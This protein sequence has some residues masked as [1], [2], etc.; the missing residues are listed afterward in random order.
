MSFVG[1]YNDLD[2]GGVIT[3]SVT[4]LTGGETY[5][6]RLRS[7]NGNGTS[8]NSGTMTVVQ[9]P[10]TPVATAA[11][12]VTDATFQANWNSSSGADGYKIDVA[13]DAGF[14]SIVVGY[15]NKDVGTATSF[16]V[17]GLNSG[18]TYYYQI[19]SYS[20][21]RTSGNSN[22][23]TVLTVP[24][25]PAATA[26]TSINE[27]SF[28][29]NWNSSTGATK[30]YLD[31]ATNNSFTTF[32]AGFNNKDVGNVTNYSVSGLSANSNYYYRI[33]SN[34][35]TGTS[36][37][38]GT[39]NVLSAPAIPTATAATS[40]INTSFNANWN[41]STGAAGYRLDVSTVSNF[42]SFV[43]IYNNKDVGNVITYS[44][45]GLS[46]STTY[47]Y[48]VRAYNSG[49]TSGNSG[50]INLTTAVNPSGVPTATAA[51]NIAQTSFSANWNVVAGAEGYMMDVSTDWNFGAG[52]FVT[53]F[54]NKDV[55][56]VTTYSVTGLTNGNTYYYRLRSYNIS[57]T[58]GNSGSITVLMVPGTPS[59]NSATS[60]AVTSFS[61]NWNASTGATGY[62]LDVATDIGFTS[63]V[64]GFNNQDVSNVTS[65]SVTGLAGGTTY[66]YRVRAYN[67]SGTS[68]DSGTITVLTLPS[69]STATAATSLTET[70]FDANWNAVVGAA[71]YRLDVSTDVNFG[72]G[73]FL[74]GFQDKD[75]SGV[76]TYSISGLTSGTNYYYRL[77]AYNATGTGA[78]SNTITALT[79]PSAPVATAATS[80][81]GTS[82]SSNWNSSSGATKYY[83][84]VATDSGFGAG[85]F[86]VGYQDKDV[87]VVTTYSVSGLTVN[88]NYYYRV[89]SFNSSG[90]SGNSNTI[91][92]LTAPLAP[93]ALA[94]TSS[95][96]SS[97]NANWNAAA[98]ATKY[99]LDV[100]LDVNFVG[101]SFET[102]YE[103][104]DVSNVVTYS[105][106]EITAGTSHYYRVR[107][108]N[109]DGISGNSGTITVLGVP[110]AS[111]ATAIT[112]TSFSSNWDAVTGITGYR[113]DVSTDINFS[114]G[115]FVAGFQ[116]KDVGNV[117][118]FPVTG[119]TPNTTYFY[120]V[121]SYD[122]NYTSGNSNTIIVKNLPT[123]TV[124]TNATGITQ[125][126]FI[127]N[128][129]AS[130]GGAY[131]YIID[132]ASDPEFVNYVTG[133]ENK[134]VYNVTSYVINN[135]TAGTVY[136]YRVRAY[137]SLG[138]SDNSNTINLLTIPSN[139]TATVASNI[140]STSFSAN[141]NAVYGA[142]KYYL[143]VATDASFTNILVGYNNIDVANVTTF[144]VTNISKNTLFYF[145]A[146][147]NNTTG[148]SG[149]SNTISISTLP[150]YAPILNG[151][152][153][154][155]LDFTEGDP[156]QQITSSIT[157]NDLDNLNVE[158]AVVQ[159]ITNYQ[160]DED[161]L[162]FIN[163]NG[164]TGVWNQVNGT[165]TLLG[166]ATVAQYQ[167]AI[168]NVKYQNT[169]NCPKGLTRTLSVTVNDGIVN[170]N[171]LT[172]N[173]SIA[174]I[175]TPPIISSIETDPLTYKIKQSPYT[176]TNSV[177]VED[178]DDDNNGAAIITITEN[179][180]KGED[181][182][183]F[184]NQNGIIG[185]WD[186]DK[187]ILYL[188]GNSSVSNYQAAL[189]TV[190]YKNNK[191]IPNI[192][193][194]TISIKFNDG[195]DD[196]DESNIVFRKIVFPNS[197]FAPFLSY[198]E[199]SIIVYSKNSDRITVSDSIMVSDEDNLFLQ[200][201]E[202]K[203]EEGFLVG[204]DVLEFTAPPY[205]NAFYNWSNGTLT[206]SGQSDLASYENIFR[207]V[208][209][210]NIRGTESTKSNKTIVFSVNDGI[211][212]SNKA[213]RQISVEGT[214]TGVDDLSL[215]IPTE[216]KLYQNYPNP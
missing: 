153:T 114:A 8:N 28:V 103:N 191:I 163:Q 41:A 130:P 94:A 165:M 25:A 116:N 146:K 141:W 6:Y 199:K 113:L 26:A 61:A 176:L 203:I 159:I 180:Q 190:C 213:K 75:V 118:T 135:V 4:G 178:T 144:S 126:S 86:V 37:N 92:V 69:S 53:N 93:V 56:N 66:Y 189:R 34:N 81:T 35:A 32:V 40:I 74:S 45:T 43:G 147:S 95:A 204:E 215:G 161:I 18:T 98:G 206:L 71:G 140:T 62:Y 122:L 177:V 181:E 187:G 198:I 97:F 76:T 84:D 105:V 167:T 208:R 158:N 124:A 51:T 55:G 205:I 20:A 194:R 143:D 179:Y 145:R 15:N 193:D 67:G 80:V 107:S 125:T 184:E 131:G 58:S 216:F 17:T 132:V 19:R 50:T 16:V 82:F 60:L 104:K 38:S 87:G 68:G 52:T 209:Y 90:T 29:A 156:P 120:R 160:S 13:T 214:I 5:Y 195:D 185:N 134:V 85:T 109:G 21:S 138:T 1:I 201:G 207:S 112:Q 128:W 186:S 96:E 89:R 65:Y 33:R 73:T 14:S 39:I 202:V 137:N 174:S 64:A 102:G 91:T 172:R 200:R 70:T 100:S 11:S 115:F 42:T 47:Y 136:Y 27:S 182:L 142:D 9:A 88:T 175:N 192:I 211:E 2:V 77:R 197:N 121:R 79:F 83:L 57:G 48:R 150:N 123:A 72:A 117:T 36:G 44:V 54:E 152:E 148:T 149:N 10:V 106:T 170:S 173:I 154:S 169:S 171:I 155:S 166:T 119:L 157:V 49:G 30:Y 110:N 31:V 212:N 63:F 188:C 164:I 3:R 162:F 129:N 23:I 111:S 108:S 101:G 196:N 99:Y 133:Y 127:A 139:P 7:Y 24:S 22:S 210:K 151:I 168:R 78:N 46:G 183:I 59:A 12:S